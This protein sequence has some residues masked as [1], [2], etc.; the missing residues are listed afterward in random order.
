MRRISICAVILSMATLAQAKEISP[1]DLCRKKLPQ[2]KSQLLKDSSDQ[3]AWLEI[4]TCSSEL[5]QWDDAV[6][7][8]MSTMK[9]DPQ[10]PNPRIILG[11]AQMNGKDYERA[12]EHFDKAIEL[13]PNQPYA[14]F[15]MGMAY[16]FLSQPDKAAM[17]ASRAVE[18][19]PKNAVYQHQAAY[20][21]LLLD[22]LENAEAAAKAAIAIDPDDLAAQKVLAKVYAKEGKAT[23]SAEAAAT[24]KALMAKHGPLVAE[25]PVLAPKVAKEKEKEETKLDDADIIAQILGHWHGMVESMLSGDNER[26]LSFFSDYLDTRD[27]Y[28][29]S[30]AKLGPRA[31]TIFANFG[32]PYDCEV[33][34]QTAT[35]KAYVTNARGVPKETTIRFERNPDKVWRIRS[36]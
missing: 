13:S 24:A 6:E 5:K 1:K 16:L 3:E 30:F 33:V 14:Y 32:E 25:T 35:C 27:Q 12:I 28:R 29:Q 26:A 8:A 34:L 10:N 2:L 20:A 31:K 36:F 11:M 17:A 19:E 9:K 4:R 22:D 23:E 21:Y 15:Q 18:L 7:A